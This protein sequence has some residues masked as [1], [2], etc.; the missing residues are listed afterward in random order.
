MVVTARAAG[1]E[2][3]RTARSAARVMS[4]ESEPEREDGFMETREEIFRER[5][6]E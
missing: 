5:H 6:N 3:G 1:M 4:A 2:E